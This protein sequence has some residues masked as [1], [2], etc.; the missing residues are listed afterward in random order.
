ME[1]KSC[2][3]CYWKLDNY[4]RWCCNNKEK[5]KENVC[6]EHNFKCKCG[7]EAGYKYNGKVYCSDCVLKEFGV[8]ECTTTEYYLDGEF[9]GT[10]NDIDE[11]IEIL[12]EIEVI[13]D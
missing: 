9:L 7:N 12:D 8:E 5:P 13:E 2:E 1:E 11:V 6:K 4:S 3:N 10:S